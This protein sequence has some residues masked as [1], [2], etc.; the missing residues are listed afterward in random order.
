MIDVMQSCS[1][2]AHGSRAEAQLRIGGLIINVGISNGKPLSDLTAENR[3][4]IV[5]VILR[6]HMLVAKYAMKT[7]QPGASI[8]FISSVASRLPMGRQPAYETSKAALIQQSRDASY[9]NALDLAVDG[10]LTNGLILG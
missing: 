7:L 2:A 8:V 5:N 3:D 6:G 1:N 9:V 10:E 4:E